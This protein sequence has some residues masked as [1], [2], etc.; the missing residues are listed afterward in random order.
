FISALHGNG[1]PTL[2]ATEINIVGGY[3]FGGGVLNP[4]PPSTGVAQQPDPLANLPAPTVGA[5][6]DYNNYSIGGNAVLTLNPG[7]YCGGIYVQ[8]ATV[9][10]GAGTY[11]LKGGGLRTQS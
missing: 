8:N 4:D 5:G 9:T 3:N 7:I 10:F 1:T 11:I 6:C 2:S